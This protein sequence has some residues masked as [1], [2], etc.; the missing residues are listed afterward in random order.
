VPAFLSW[1]I[2]RLLPRSPTTNTSNKLGFRRYCGSAAEGVTFSSMLHV[3]PGDRPR[4]R[5]K[6]ASQEKQAARKHRTWDETVR[7][8]ITETYFWTF[9]PS[10]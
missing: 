9:M 5:N 10:Q 1:R 7:L 4:N 6:H 3:M 2:N 8:Q